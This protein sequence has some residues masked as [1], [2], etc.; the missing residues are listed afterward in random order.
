MKRKSNRWLRDGLQAVA[1]P[2]PP[3]P[4]PQFWAAFEA[5]ARLAPQ[6]PASPEAMAPAR[7][8]LLV[9]GGWLGS[10]AVFCLL[11]FGVGRLFLAGQPPAE[12]AAGSRLSKVETI[13][14]YAD[15]SSVFVLEDSEHQVTL[16]WLAGLTPAALANGSNANDLL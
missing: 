9:W 15:C 7:S 12:L 5:R 13:N 14:V 1:P 4:R 11:L 2:P 10:V 16:V 6:W 3:P 8:P